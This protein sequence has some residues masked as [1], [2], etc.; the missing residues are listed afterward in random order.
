MNLLTKM[1]GALPKRS[2][3]VPRITCGYAYPVPKNLVDWSSL[4]VLEA[5]EDWARRVRENKD[6]QK[7]LQN[8]SEQERD[9]WWAKM[10]ATAAEKLEDDAAIWFLEDK[11]REQAVQVEQQTKLLEGMKNQ[12]LSM[13]ADHDKKHAC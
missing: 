12:L 9:F 13:R 1:I 7:F 10:V 3:G 2:S 5:M 8:A 6:A 11:I 4:S